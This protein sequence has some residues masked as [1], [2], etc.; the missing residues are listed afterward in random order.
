MLLERQRELLNR[1]KAADK[2]GP[3]PLAP[4]TMK[5]PASAYTDPQRFA[6]ERETL[7]E[8]RPQMIALSCDLPSPGSHI[9]AQLGRIPALIVRQPDGSLKGFVNACR[10]R[11]A[12]VVE[13]A[14]EPGGH[15]PQRQARPRFACPYHGWVYELD[16][17]LHARPY[18][19]AAFDDVPKAECGLLPV[20]VAEG[21]GLV[22]AQGIGGEGLTAESALHGAES[23]LAGYSLG[24]CVHVESRTHEWDFNW[25]LVLDT[26][27]ESYHIRF[28][29]RLSIAPTYL[30]DLSLYDS[31]GPHPRMIGLLKT[32]LDEIEKPEEEWRLLPHGTT[33]YIFMPSGL[34]T[35]QRDHVEL[36]RV[37][38]LS[39]NRTRVRTSL[40]AP[41]EPTTDKARNYWRKNLDALIDVTS[42]ED[43]T[44]MAQIQQRLESGALPELI[45][46]KNEP[47]LIHLHRS[48]NQALAEPA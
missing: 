35:W 15:E 2:S 38:P 46:G 25:K 36:W 16:G 1:L 14:A 17:S 47:S 40:Y 19:E 32:A 43:F 7:F 22:F 33:Q 48:I 18:A 20:S 44:L 4:A 31:F 42:R 6:R 10:H 28:L 11:G 45:Y 29:H 41:T 3:W 8:R 5:N 21:Y 34:I 9:T 26:F 27:T 23:E 30:A 13:T 37:T 12:P 39:A 24:T